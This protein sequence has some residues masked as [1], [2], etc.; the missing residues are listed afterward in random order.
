VLRSVKELFGYSLR[1]SDGG[2][3]SVE[4]V[5]FDDRAWTVRYIVADTGG[6]L[7]GRRVLIS[8]LSAGRIDAR[9]QS[10]PLSLT[11]KQVE[12]SP[13]I[14]AAVTVARQHEEALTRYY[15]WP[16]YWMDGISAPAAMGAAAEADTEASG[17]Q[18]RALA[19]PSHLR[20]VREISSYHIGATDGEIG[21]VHDFIFDD[22]GW[23]IRY[24]VVDTRSWLPGK[25]VL[26]ARDW[27]RSVSWAE[28]RV[29]VDTN[30]ERIRNSPP[31]DPAEP[32]NREYELQLYDYYGRPKY[33]TRR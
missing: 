16:A 11:R 21:H 8:P 13:G 33:W 23:Q 14:D 15:A 20:S 32:V 5:Y 7:T 4:D 9:T 29:L 1:A 28:Q 10:M 30:R 12:E 24:V 19:P 6:W 3:G 31:F 25:K 2:I 18:A 26:V 27:I 17:G 22:E